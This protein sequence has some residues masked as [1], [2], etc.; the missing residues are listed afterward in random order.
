MV[1]VNGE[2]DEKGNG[3]DAASTKVV[4]ARESDAESEATIIPENENG[5]GEEQIPL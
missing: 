2:V 1:G 3:D 5:L 4:Y